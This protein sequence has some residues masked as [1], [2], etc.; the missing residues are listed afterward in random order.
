M[1]TEREL[2]QMRKEQE[3]FMPDK[4]IIKERKFFGDTESDY[5]AIDDEFHP[6]RIIPGFGVWRTVADRF[7]GITAYVLTFTW[8]ELVRPG[9]IAVHGST[10][11]E[12]RDVKTDSSYQT[13]L[14]ALCDRTTE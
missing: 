8:D 12:I 11:Y 6:C 3:K 7:Q 4:V 14:Q 10:V 1:I 2:E 9:Y 5:Y 13:A